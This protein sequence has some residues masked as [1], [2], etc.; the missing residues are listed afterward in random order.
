MVAVVVSFVVVV[1]PSSLFCLRARVGE[2]RNR[3]LPLAKLKVASLTKGGFVSGRFPLWLCTSVWRTHH[4]IP[5]RRYLSCISA[6]GIW[7]TSEQSGFPSFES[8]DCPPWPLRRP[9]LPR[10]R[11]S[12]RR[13]A[14]GYISDLADALDSCQLGGREAS[15]PLFLPRMAPSCRF[16][17]PRHGPYGCGK[18]ITLTWRPIEARGSSLR[19]QIRLT[20][21][22]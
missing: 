20:S 7:E 6:S 19:S 22:N 13:L 14:T 8:I 12:V 9:N 1:W 3:R 2:P 11:R 16:D 15:S 17:E 4:V 18:A 21:E 10:R 5:L